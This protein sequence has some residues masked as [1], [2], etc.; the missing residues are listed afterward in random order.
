MAKGVV[1]SSG[2]CIT[3]DSVLEISFWVIW[4]AVAQA[5]TNRQEVI[6]AQRFGFFIDS[7]SRMSKVK[8][9]TKKKV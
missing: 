2:V 1:G 6:T 7:F 9:T 8:T 5:A 4:G 3:S